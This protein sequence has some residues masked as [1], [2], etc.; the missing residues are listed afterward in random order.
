MDLSV[1]V[2]SW[3]VKNLLEAC[4]RSVESTLAAG[5]LTWQLCVVDNAS[6]DDSPQ[7]VRGRFP[8]VTLIANTDNLGYAGACN[9][10]LAWAEGDNC[11]VLNP[12]TEVKPGALAALVEFLR[13]TPTAGMAGPRL[14]YPDGS[15]Q[16]SAFAFPGLVQVA[17]DLFPAP[18]RLYE[19]RCNGRYPRSWYAA[20]R[21]FRVGHPLGACIMVRKAALDGVGRMDTGFFMYCEEVDWA[22]RF[23]GA[24]WQVYCVPA[25]EV[26]HHAG[27][28]TEQVRPEMFAALWRSRLRYYDK[29][30]GPV[31]TGV[32]RLLLRA[33]LRYQRSRPRREAARGQLSQEAL[34]QREE[35]YRRAEQMLHES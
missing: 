18:G 9:Q 1:V 7:M 35:M 24:G 27:R 16:H 4:L 25:A 34:A 5:S 3:N 22:R 26:V 31:Y 23:Q 6:R 13:S 14:I 2:V 10:G 30:Y 15:F 17:L 12:D 19:S 28:S 11:L 20:G 29:H 33:G 32:V 21:P 8:Q